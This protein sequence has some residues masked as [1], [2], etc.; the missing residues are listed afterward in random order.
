MSSRVRELDPEDPMRCSGIVLCHTYYSSVYELELLSGGSHDMYICKYELEPN[1][2][3]PRTLDKSNPLENV[4]CL[5][6]FL[7]W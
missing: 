5:V 1:Y 2:H 4:H 6:H 3:M 7:L